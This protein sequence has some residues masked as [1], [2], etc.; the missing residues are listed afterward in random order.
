[1]TKLLQTGRPLL[2]IACLSAFTGSLLAQSTH[3]I[4]RA[5]AKDGKFISTNIGGALVV[6]RDHQSGELLA[7]GYTEGA[8][9]STPL[10]ME[11]AHNRND[12]LTDD[13]TAKFEAVIDLK[14]PVF[15][16]VQV[17]GPAQLRGAAITGTTQLWLIPGK[18]IDGDGLII[19]LP[20]LIVNVLSP[21]LHQI[22][23]IKEGQTI[24]IDLSISLTMLCGCTI[25]KAGPW[26]ADQIE[27][28]ATLT[29]DGKPLES[30]PLNLTDRDNIF[31]ARF[32]VNS[33]GSY[34]I[35]IY[36]YDKVTKNTGVEHQ[37]FFVN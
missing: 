25:S 1:M 5:K 10:L 13:K 30:K 21:T 23:P 28:G 9:G 22:L 17:T 14:E 34:G 33:K 12:R 8:S 35:T 7:K 27:V 2:L 26:K 24:N 18:N 29:K 20:G 19:E 11:T 37:Y 31:G 36:A 3:L 15:A 6:I 16:D 32:T 4:V